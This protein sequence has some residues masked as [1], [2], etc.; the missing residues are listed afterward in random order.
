MAD[1]FT[2][3]DLMTATG[4]TFAS[5][6][7]WQTGQAY[8]RY[9]TLVSISHLLG[10]SFEELTGKAES[11]LA[12]PIRVSKEAKSPSSFEAIARRLDAINHNIDTLRQERDVLKRQMQT[13]LDGLDSDT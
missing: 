6:S 1:K 9:A 11:E 13:Y 12:H 3:K 4:A 2:T 10:V 7:R 5:A 8:P